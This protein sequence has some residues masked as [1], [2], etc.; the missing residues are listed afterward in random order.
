M[1]SIP[2]DMPWKTIFGI[3]Y[4]SIF[5]G[6]CRFYI[7]VFSFSYKLC[8]RIFEAKPFTLHFLPEDVWECQVRDSSCLVVGEWIQIFPLQEPWW[9]CRPTENLSSRSRVPQSL[10]PLVPLWS[11]DG[12]RCV[13]TLNVERCCM[14]RQLHSCYHNTLGFWWS[15]SHS[16]LV[17]TS[18][19]EFEH[20]MKT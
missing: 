2:E 10:F 20:S 14:I 8:T 18:S 19:T 15:H 17:V 9:R 16:Q 11:D 1:L 3:F 7:F 13:W 6:F 4:F 12:C 5:M